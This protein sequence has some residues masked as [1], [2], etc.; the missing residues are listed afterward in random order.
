MAKVIIGVDPHKLSATI[1]VVDR[2]EKLLGSGRFSTDQAGY[3]AMRTYAKTWPDRVWA[4]KGS[5]GAGRPLAQRLLEAGEHVVDV[6]A[7]LAARVP[8]FDTGH[9]RKT[10]ARDAHSIAVVAVRTKDLRMLRA[11]GELEALRM[12]CDRREE[13]TRLRVQTVPRLH[14]LLAELVPGT[15]KKDLTALQ[16]KAILATVRPRDIAGKTRRRIAAEELADLVAVE[17]KMKKSTAELKILV[18]ARDSRLMDLHGVGP[19]V[20]ARTLADVGDVHRFNDRSRFAS[21]TG[22]TT[23]RLLRR[24][25]P[26]PTLPSREPADEPHDPH[27]RDQPDPPRHRGPY[28][29]QAQARRREDQTRSTALP[30][31]QDL[32]RALPTAARRCRPSSTQR[33]TRP[34]W[35]GSG[36]ALRGDSSIQR[37]RPSPA[38]RHFGSATSRTRTTDATTDPVPPEESNQNDL[39]TTKGSRNGLRRADTRSSSRPPSIS[40]GRCPTAYVRCCT[41]H[42]CRG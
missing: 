27:R 22:R 23:G 38:H 17:A 3:T 41:R 34:G 32:R 31:A 28:L 6:P 30:Q 19:V 9:N 37:G 11:D 13:L 42:R 12:L 40:R 16:A 4:I 1:E 8:L 35:H 39:L 18:K 21:W 5:N 10:D 2:H 36:R 26:A 15:A 25:E 33:H 24:A 29:L 20:A 7:K 14:R